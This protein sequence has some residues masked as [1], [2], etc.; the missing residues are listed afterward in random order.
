MNKKQSKQLSNKRKLMMRALQPQI[1][2]K[3]CKINSH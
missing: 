1:T 3:T 2:K